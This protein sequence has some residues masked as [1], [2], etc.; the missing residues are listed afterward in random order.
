MVLN[1]YD[2][3]LE[4]EAVLAQTAPFQ[5]CSSQLLWDVQWWDVQRP[6]SMHGAAVTLPWQPQGKMSPPMRD[7]H[8]PS[9]R[10]LT[11]F[12]LVSQILR[13]NIINRIIL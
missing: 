11:V 1:S 8:N 13:K 9:G 12:C 7:D 2:V 6:W 5:E 3:Y 4:C 10:G